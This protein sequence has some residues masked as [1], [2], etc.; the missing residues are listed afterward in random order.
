MEIFHVHLS[1]KCRRK[2]LL[3]RFGEESTEYNSKSPCCDVCENTAEIQK[4]DHIEDLKI[5]YDAMR[6]IGP[7]GELIMKLSQWIRGSALA[8]TETHD[9]P[10]MSYGHREKKSPSTC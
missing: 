8:W 6:A 1:S 4:S 9:K 2:T 7:Q 3:E 10:S 5:L